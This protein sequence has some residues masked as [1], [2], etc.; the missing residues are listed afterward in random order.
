[1]GRTAMGVRGIRLSKG[2]LVV[3]AEM[4]EEKV[5]LLTITEKG[6]GKRSRIEDYPVQGRGGK[7]VISIKLTP[8]GGQAVGL[9]KVRDDDEVM[10]I[11][12]SGKTIRMPAQGISVI[13]RNTQGVK[14][15]DLEEDD[16][17]VGMGKVVE[18]D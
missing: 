3:S 13:G 9:M 11:T 1:M 16:R 12:H 5:L 7:G 2:D 14:L 4:V 17:I 10:L 15:M 18:K 8:K 6:M